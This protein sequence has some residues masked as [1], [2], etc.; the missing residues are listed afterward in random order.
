MGKSGTTENSQK[1]SK[2]SKN[3]TESQYL[4][5]DHYIL[6]NRLGND[7]HLLCKLLGI[8]RYSEHDGGVANLL[9][10]S[11]VVIYLGHLAAL[12]ESNSSIRV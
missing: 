3:K 11:K 9:G 2:I 8:T 7:L 4:L 12:L 5:K 1:K 6:A 10:G